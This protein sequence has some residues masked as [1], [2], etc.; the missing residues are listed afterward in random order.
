VSKDKGE[1]MF[2]SALLL[3]VAIVFMTCSEDSPVE[4]TECSTPATIKDLTG[5]DGCGFVFE[6]ED[7]TR[8]EPLRIFYCGTP[9]LPK[10]MPADPLHGFEII[11]GKKVTI[12]YD[13]VENYASTCMAGQVVKITCIQE[14]PAQMSQ[15]DH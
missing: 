13:V 8:L 3:F 10:D 6:L 2:R 1:N 14:A 11:D 15:S 5:L 7:G 4:V 12:S 9:P